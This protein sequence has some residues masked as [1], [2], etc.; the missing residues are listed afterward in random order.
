M[1]NKGITLIALVITIIV[2]LILAGVSISIMMGDNGIVT[3]AT[4]VELEYSKAEIEEKFEMLV[5][6][7][8]MEAY[9]S[10]QN[11]GT[12]ISNFYKESI[13]IPNFIESGYITAD[14]TSNT[15]SDLLGEMTGTPLY[16][17]YIINVNVLS[18]K[19][20]LY[21]KG[22]SIETGDIFTLEVKTDE[23]GKST[24]EYDV[25]YYE[26]SDSEGEILTTFSL[27]LSNNS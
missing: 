12:D 18:D 21:G 22:T 9:A 4:T 14:T 19:V 25:K 24:G 6:D 26:N 5:N 3:K 11:S 1:N 20:D 7:K 13:L 2:L 17:R 27:Y 16:S 23:A 8:L 15:V 10:I